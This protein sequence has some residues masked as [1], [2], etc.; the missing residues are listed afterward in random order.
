MYAALRYARATLVLER[1][2][3]DTIVA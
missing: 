1:V 2:G 3:G